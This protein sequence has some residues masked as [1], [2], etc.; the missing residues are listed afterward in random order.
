MKRRNKALSIEW[1][2]LIAVGVVISAILIIVFISTVRRARKSVEPVV[3]EMSAAGAAIK[4]SN[5]TAYD[6]EE[7]TGEDVRN[8]LAKYLDEY[9]GSYTSPVSF[10]VNNGSSTVTYTTRDS[11][12]KTKDSTDAA[13]YVKPNRL[14]GCTVSRNTNGEISTVSFTAK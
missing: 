12:S 9:S 2:I 1:L 4:D 3:E 5:L 14:F 8:I 7:L 13:H 10:V 6:G 11:L